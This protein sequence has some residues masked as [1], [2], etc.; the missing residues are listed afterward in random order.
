MCLGCFVSE[1]RL[2]RRGLI[3]A[4][5]LLALVLGACSSVP[6]APSMSS[7]S[8]MFGSNSSSTPTAA[9]ASAGNTLPANFECPEVQVRQGAATLTN[10]ANPAEPTAMNLRYQI[11]IGT[12]ARECRA[13]PNNMVLLKVGMQGRVILGPEGGA[14]SSV[15]V[16]LRYAVVSEAIDS[17]VITTKLDRIS[18]AIPPNDS[19][20]LFSHVTEG[21]DFPMPRGSEIDAYI[22]YIG[23]DPAGLTEQRKPKAKPAPKKPRV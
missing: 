16:P 4:S 2:P 6:S 5:G 8:S 11:T 23:F 15:D 14:P 1:F 21:L 10:S 9:N 20:V 7:W 13:G 19:N 18:V 22:V 3:I 12:F 17:K